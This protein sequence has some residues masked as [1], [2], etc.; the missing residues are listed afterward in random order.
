MIDLEKTRF[1]IT[2]QIMEYLPTTLA[3]IKNKPVSLVDFGTVVIPCENQPVPDFVFSKNRGELVFHAPQHWKL[4]HVVAAMNAFSSVGQAR[5]NGWNRNI[6]FGMS[7]HVF[8]INKTRGSVTIWKGWHET[9]TWGVPE[10]LG[11]VVQS[12]RIPAS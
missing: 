8:R 1:Q 4:C 10:K 9:I 5:K 3:W 2:S 12:V 6:P 11:L 7:Q